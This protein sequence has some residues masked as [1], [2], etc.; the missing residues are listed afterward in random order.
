V[1][2]GKQFL[3]QFVK[4]V[5]LGRIRVIPAGHG[6]NL[7]HFREA[8][9]IPHSAFNV[10]PAVLPAAARVR[11]WFYCQG[12]DYGNY[13]KQGDYSQNRKRYQYNWHL[14]IHPVNLL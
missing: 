4:C 10:R 12:A 14:H 2:I 5:K 13:Q 11:L 6:F 7:Y 8:R 9:G 1:D 3:K